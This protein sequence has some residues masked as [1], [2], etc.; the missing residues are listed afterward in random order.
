MSEPRDRSLLLRV[1]RPLWLALLTV[2][3][4]AASI[5]ARIAI[6]AHR[7][8]VAIGEI[9]RVGGS[10]DTTP[11]GSDWL[12]RLAA[13]AGLKGFDP[14][15]YI[16]LTKVERSNPEK[17]HWSEWRDLTLLTIAMTPIEDSDLEQISK[18]DQ[19]TT[20][21]LYSTQVTCAGL[22]RLEALPRLV[23]LDLAS[24]AADFITFWP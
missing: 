1:P 6:P 21:T 13:F 15:W 3:L 9:E 4:V 12:Q 2:V 7:R 18:L 16:N 20:L 17:I 8:S 14:V 5:G 11:A 10:F 22:K 24:A 23:Q 19:L